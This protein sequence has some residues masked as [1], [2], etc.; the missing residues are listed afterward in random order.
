MIETIAPI[1]APAADAVEKLSQYG[2]SA[3]CLVLVGAVVYCF[4]AMT[5]VLSKSNAAILKQIEQ[6]T[7]AQQSL[8]DVVANNTD[9]TKKTLEAMEKTNQTTCDSIDALKCLQIAIASCPKK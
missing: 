4:R 2:L 9:I 7:A 6:S 8:K 5:I 1:V 3:V